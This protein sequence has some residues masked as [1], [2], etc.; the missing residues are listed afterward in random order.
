MV[1]YHINL[2]LTHVEAFLQLAVGGFDLD[3]IRNPTVFP[4]ARDSVG[5]IGTGDE[6]RE[7]ATGVGESEVGMVAFEATE[8]DGCVLATRLAG[9][10]LFVEVIA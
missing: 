4:F 6:A 1:A 10:Y 9:P 8:W 7:A 5:L 3:V 2:V